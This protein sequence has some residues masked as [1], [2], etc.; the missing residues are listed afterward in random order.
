M[1]SPGTIRPG[2]RTGRTAESVFAAATAELAERGYADISIESIAARAGV[3]KT[4]LYRRWGSKERLI[5]QLLI[6]AAAAR[7]QVPDTG[8]VQSDVHTLARAVQAI[9]SVPEGAAITRALVVG[10]MSSAEIAQLMNR[11][12]AARLEAIS[13]IVD[14]A[15]LRGQ[16]PAGTD[17]AAFMRAIAAP[18]YYQLLVSRAPVTDKDAE[19]SAAAALAAAAAGVFVLLAPDRAS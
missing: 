10:A 2:G 12:W 16:L 9:L 15:I 18:L 14:R 6:G 4:T 3:H 13:V 5:R 17:P 1:A 8:D 19:L 7:I 11:F